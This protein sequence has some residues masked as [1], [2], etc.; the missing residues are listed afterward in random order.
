MLIAVRILLP[1]IIVLWLLSYFDFVMHY[2]NDE[3]VEFAVNIRRV[4]TDARGMYGEINCKQRVSSTDQSNKKHSFCSD[5]MAYSNL[6]DGGVPYIDD[7]DAVVKG[8]TGWMGVVVD[9]IKWNRQF[10][11]EDR[12]WSVDQQKY[13]YSK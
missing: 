8:R 7:S 4:S 1:A 6:V 5:N 13:I 9:A 10:T 12:A 3:P 2:I 11:A